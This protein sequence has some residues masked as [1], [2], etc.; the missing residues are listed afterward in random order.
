MCVSPWL[1]LASSVIRTS[2]QPSTFRGMIPSG[3]DSVHSLSL[4]VTFWEVGNRAV[5]LRS[6]ALRPRLTTGLP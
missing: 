4:T 5:Y 6:L 3:T 1:P 2:C